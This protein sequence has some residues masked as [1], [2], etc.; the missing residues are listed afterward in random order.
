M[1]YNHTDYARWGPV[2]LAEMHQLP[3]EVLE[4][5]KTGNF[6]VKWS[7][8]N[9]KQ[10][11]PDQAQE[12]LNATGKKGRGVVGITKTAS[13]LSR[14]ALSYNLRSHVAAETA[15]M[16]NCKM[17]DSLVH[18]EGGK[19]QEKHDNDA[20]NTLY[21]TLQ[22]FHTF[23]SC[24]SSEEL[25]NI[26]TKDLAT[27]KIEH[28]L[29][30]ARSL[31][32][33]QLEDFIKDRL[34]QNPEQESKTTLPKNNPPTFA[35]LYEVKKGEASTDKIKILTAD[36]NILHRL[37]TAYVA[38]REVNI[39]DVLMHELM[40]V[41]VSIPE[42]N[43]K[44]RCGN[45]SV[46]VEV[47]TKEVTC[48][49][50]VDLE[51]DSALVIDGFALIAAVGKPEKAK[52]FGDLSDVFVSTVLS[53][54]TAYKRVDMVID[55]YREKSIKASTRTRQSRNVRAIWRIIEDQSVPLP[56]NW[57]KMLLFQPVIQ[58]CSCS[59]WLI[60]KG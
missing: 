14:W 21:S 38:G 25:Q 45:K 41:P 57:L 46:L 6:V 7:S 19:S 26:T 5:F 54:G 40:P 39:Q 15:V 60:E 34:L 4:E 53:K 3:A 52:T 37:I 28:S 36:R 27:S 24:L 10:V 33:S 44:L 56:S 18:K 20:E 32:Q 50:T 59:C 42:T 8:A 47:L 11:S 58:M 1:R 23:S 30:N 29:L 22:R 51:G 49:A 16:F 9:C 43:Q 55:R 48:P 2:Y 12:W 17:D 13:A 31:G 35:S